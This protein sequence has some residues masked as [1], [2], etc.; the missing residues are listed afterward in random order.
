M[1]VRLALLVAAVTAVGTSVSAQ[2]LLDPG[3]AAA[4]A[5]RPEYN[6]YAGELTSREIIQAKAAAKSARRN[7]VLAARQWY[8]YSQARPTT[9]STP[10]TG[11]YGAH[12][13]RYSAGRSGYGF[14]RPVFVVR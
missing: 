1:L 13:L 5:E 10:F 11:T 7:A 14:Q 4:T 3:P 8:G 9:M 2:G 12:S 6:G